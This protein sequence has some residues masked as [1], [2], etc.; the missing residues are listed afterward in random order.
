[1]SVG[2]EWR[3]LDLHVHTGASYD[4]NGE[5]TPKDIVDEALR[6]NLDAI[7]ITDH[8]TGEW[9]DKIKEAAKGTSLVIFP[10]VE[11]TCEGGKEGIHI[12][13]LFDPSKDTQHV[14]GLLE[15][16]EIRYDEKGGKG[17]QGSKE[18]LVAEKTGVIGV[19]EL[20]SKREGIAIPAHV[21]SSKGILKD[22]RGQQRIRIIQDPRLVAVEATDFDKEPRKRTIDFLNGNDPNYQRK[23][24]VYQASDNREPSGNGH[25]L[26][27]IGTRTTYFNLD[28]INLEGLRQC[29]VHP[30]AR[31]KLHREKI[32]C[33]RILS[34]KI[35]NS[36]FL[37]SQNFKFHHGLNSII[38]GKGV[39]KS[40]VIEFMRFCLDDSSFDPGLKADHLGK[41]DKQLV[42]GNLVELIYQ[43]SAGSKY[44][45]T[46]TY[47]G[48]KGKESTS[49]IKCV[50]LESGK[51][52]SGDIPSMF[53]ILAYSQ[54]EVIKISENKN[55]QLEL[56]DRFIDNRAY[57]KAIESTEN[58]LCDN[59]RKL[60]RA[61]ECTTRLEQ[62][63]FD[64]NTLEEEI[65]NIDRAL[66][67]ELFDK[68]K[69]GED[70]KRI[71]NNCVDSVEEISTNIGSWLE[72]AKEWSLDDVEDKW[73]DDVQISDHHNLTAETYQLVQKSLQQLKISIEKQSFDIKKQFEEWIPEFNTLQSHYNTLIEQQGGD[74]KQQ[75]EK[76]QRLEKQKA[77]LEDSAKQDREVAEILTENISERNHLLDE[78]DKA[79][80]DYYQLR[81]SK[82]DELTLSSNGK[83]SLILNHA[84]NRE[85]YTKKIVDLLKG[86]TNALSTGHRRQIANS[87]TPRRFVN[88]VI[89]HNY[90]DLAKESELTN[91]WAQRV[92]EKLWAHENFVEV[93]S[94]QHSFYPK[95]VP[96]IQYAK[97]KGV[98]SELNELSVGQKC[99][100]L[101]IVALSDGNNPV[102]IDQPEDA[103][104]I[105]SVWQDV[106]KKLLDE[107]HHRQFILTTHNSSIAVSADSDQFIVLDAD[108][109]TGKIET[110]GAIDRDAVK[111]AVIELLEGG[112]EP[113]ELRQMKYNKT[114]SPLSN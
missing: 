76:R 78:L 102:I 27:G 112:D 33:P 8:N 93:L 23:L 83:L 44:Q 30:D 7:A 68:M 2:L 79:Y 84:E 3:K 58:K 81:K 38:G 60:A 20:V 28:V 32:I 99:T 113:Y 73:A 39:G 45:I 71:L 69:R 17:R 10:G 4:F 61:L 19:I 67:N 50:N 86:G 65:G 105:V 5:V 80:Q 88:L 114:T 16:L 49:Q 12:I 47:T 46:R 52:Y 22:M 89:D 43:T 31:I 9:I 72:E 29:F 21:N 51:E 41:L 75:E 37:N 103:L 85:H 6:K 62:T 64:I 82:F 57:I 56:I 70:K 94:L 35:G 54:T 15:A 36:G 100:A 63:Q 25:C 77:K 97:A 13:A 109:T 14:R 1:M 59:D 95:D 110:E 34:L 98:Y 74:Q 90:E 108:A 104:D 96:K 111:K 92:I 11:I 55:A 53:P 24:A 91:T 48:K 42:S 107:K 26:E 106:A 87:I 66:S 18:A 40:L 101:L